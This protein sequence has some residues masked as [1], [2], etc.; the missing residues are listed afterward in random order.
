MIDCRSRDAL[1]GVRFVR[2]FL[3][4]KVIG[5]EEAYDRHV[6]LAQPLRDLIVDAPPSAVA[7][8]DDRELTVRIRHGKLAQR[9]VSHARRRNARREQR[10]DHFNPSVMIFASPA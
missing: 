10:G 8:E 2:Q 3:L 4:A 7:G 5:H 9:Q 6:I 1:S